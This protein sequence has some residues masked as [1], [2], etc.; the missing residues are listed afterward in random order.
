[1]PVVIVAIPE[2]QDRVHKVSSEKVPHLTMMYLG[3]D[4]PADALQRIVLFVEHAASQIKRFGLTVDHRGE[5]GEEKADV[6]FFEKKLYVKELK[7]TLANLL[8]NRDIYE[9]YNSTT[10]FPDWLPH[11]TL[12]YPE[13]PADDE[14]VDYGIS[15]VSFDRI[16]VWTGDYDGPEFRLKGWDDMAEAGW[17]NT[18]RDAGAASIE[19]ALASM[20]E[21]GEGDALQFGVKGMKWGVR[22]SRKELAKASADA[23]PDAIK[24]VQTQAKINAAGSLNVV[25]SKD[26]QQLVDRI[27]LEEKYI[28]AT[29]AGSSTTKKGESL[30][31]KVFKNE[32]DYKLRN[33]DGPILSAYKAA[34]AAREKKAATAI[35]AAA[36]AAT[37]S[38]K[39]KGKKNPVSQTYRMGK[40]GPASRRT[41]RAQQVYNVTTV[42]G[43][44]PVTPLVALPPRRN[45]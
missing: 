27:K 45:P 40:T 29:L 9:A 5:L 13:A 41:K 12:G 39:P 30:L 28:N 37:S 23:D 20:Q 26:L 34:K 8:T 1:M 19:R 38:K 17:S 22:R 3:D 33:E 11:L 35:K 31:K 6:L 18:H 32:I 7:D 42:G 10:Q 36:K 44:N 21:V 2:E 4:V 16:A 43:N 25:S 14:A 15:Y 24:A